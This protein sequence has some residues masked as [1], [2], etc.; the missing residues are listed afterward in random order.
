[1]ETKERSHDISDSICMMLYWKEKK[2]K[3]WKYNEYKK[4]IAI[5]YKDIFEN[6]DKFRYKKSPPSRPS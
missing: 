3:E 5:E 4:N 2:H 1:M 6:L